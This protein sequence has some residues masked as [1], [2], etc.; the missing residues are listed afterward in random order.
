MSESATTVLERSAPPRATIVAPDDC[1]KHYHVYLA[2]PTRGGVRMFC[3]RREARFETRTP[4]QRWAEKQQPDP[5]LRMVM[6]CDFDPKDCPAKEPVDIAERRS[7][8]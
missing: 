1:S 5:R 2:K 8:R 4:A 6:R 7:D 3:T